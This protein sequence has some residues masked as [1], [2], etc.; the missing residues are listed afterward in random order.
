MKKL[1]KGEEVVYTFEN[2]LPRRQCKR[3][4]ST[5]KD[6]G[7]GIFDWP[8]RTQDISGDPIVQKLQK[9]LNKIFNLN[10][11]ITQAQTQNWNQTSFSDLHIHNQRGRENTT[12]SSSIYLNDGFSG[13]RFF[14]KNGIKIKPTVGLLTFFNGKK[15]WHGVEKVKD[16]DR[17]ALI[18]WWK[19]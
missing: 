3:Y 15:V 5:I 13:G 12:Y 1:Q 9:F 8:Q 17:K 18:F 2:Y 19:N 10:L 7:V 4:A 16:K 14:T 6:L 11:T